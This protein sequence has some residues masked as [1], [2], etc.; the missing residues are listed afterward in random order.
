[1]ALATLQDTCVPGV[2]PPLKISLSHSPTLASSLPQDRLLCQFVQMPT[3]PGH[4]VLHGA[5]PQNLFEIFR[6]AGPLVA[7]RVGVDVGYPQPVCTVEYWKEEHANHAR[8][9]MRTIH[10]STRQSPQFMLRTFNPCKLYCTVSPFQ[11]SY[12]SEA[13]QSPE[14]RH[15][16]QPSRIQADVRTCKTA[17]SFCYHALYSHV[18]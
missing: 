17:E 4:P 15:F 16:H 12:A 10:E 2:N 1:M 7:V 14:P 18:I 11:I 3:N 13:E 5:S 8:Q 9:A 6:N